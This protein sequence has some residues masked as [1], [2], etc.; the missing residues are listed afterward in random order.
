[1]SRKIAFARYEL[2][3]EERGENGPP[4]VLVHSTG[5]SSKQWRRLS[6]RL[7]ERHRVLLPDLIGYG[8]STAWPRGEIF[9]WHLDVLAI[10]A[11][12]DALDAPA[13]LVGHSYGGLVALAAALHRPRAVRS[14]S[15][16]EPVA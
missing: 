6:E 8:E 13:H 7:S 14:L 11:T 1:M 10:E 3:V 5:M 16:I 12:L 2:S 9:H 15:L 4:V